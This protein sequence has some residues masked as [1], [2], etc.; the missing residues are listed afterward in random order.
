MNDGPVES[1][2]IEVMMGLAEVKSVVSPIRKQGKKAG[3]AVQHELKI[4][5]C[6]GG[7]RL[8]MGHSLGAAGTAS[9]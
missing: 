5:R 9:C 3:M 2:V 4:P 8:N 7:A 1:K 6:A